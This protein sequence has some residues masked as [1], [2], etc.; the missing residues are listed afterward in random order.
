[1]TV[2]ASD[3]D[4]NIDYGEPIITSILEKS[5]I[6][7]PGV[8]IFESSMEEGITSNIIKNVSNT[9]SNVN[10]GEGISTSTLGT[11][12]VTPP[13]LPPSLPL[14]T[15]T[16]ILTYVPVVSLSFQVVMQEPITTFFHPNQ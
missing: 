7:P 12:D 2:N 8:H 4:T 9:D 5:I 10:M 3:A 13:L 1:M 11:S 16:I 6:T 14:P 15:Y